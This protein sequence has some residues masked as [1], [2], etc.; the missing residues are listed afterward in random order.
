MESG[1]VERERE[2]ERVNIIVKNL[3]KSF[4]TSESVDIK[5]TTHTLLIFVSYIRW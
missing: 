5:E 3:K 4:F 2:R 1:R